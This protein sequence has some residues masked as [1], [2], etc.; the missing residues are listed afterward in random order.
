MVSHCRTRLKGDGKVNHV[1]DCTVERESQFVRK[2]SISVSSESTFQHAMCMT[3]V[4]GDRPMF[5]QNWEKQE[6]EFEEAVKDQV[7]LS[8]RVKQQEEH[9][10]KVQ[11]LA[12]QGDFFIHGFL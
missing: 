11:N 10:T 8:L 2:K 12:K 6:K 9:L 7:K 3:T 4:G 1:L 5:G